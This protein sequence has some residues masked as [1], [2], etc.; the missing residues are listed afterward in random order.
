M[1]CTV[2]FHENSSIFKKKFLQNGYFFYFF[3]GG[4]VAEFVKIND[5]LSVQPQN[6]FSYVNDFF[7]IV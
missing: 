1:V 6:K 4:G 5:L 2:Y 7:I 3:L